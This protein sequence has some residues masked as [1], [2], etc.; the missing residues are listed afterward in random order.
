MKKFTLLFTIAV[1][2][3]TMAVAQSFT[4][5][6]TFDSIKAPV[7]TPPVG[8][9]GL[10]DPSPLPT[11]VTGVTFGAF[12]AVLTTATNPNAASRFSFV[13]WPAGGTNG[14]DVYSAGTI[15]TAEYYQVTLTP[16]SG[17]SISLTGITFKTQRSGTG[18]RNYAVRSSADSYAANLSASISPANANLSVQT[19]NVFF[20]ALDATTSGQVGSTITLS[21]A[22]FTNITSPITFRFY[23]WNSEATTGTFSI[24]DVAFMGSVGGTT[25]SVNDFVNAPVAV[26]YPNP[27]TDGIFTVN[28][29]SSVKTTVT[30]Y[31]IIGKVIFTKEINSA[32]ELIDLSYEANGSYFVNIKN[33]KENVTK[34]VTINK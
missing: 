1:I 5:T 34:K 11:A 6:Y 31:N 24:D 9:S 2:S 19:G 13:D 26:V 27:S 25:T 23:G 21:G 15:N 30:V 32:K 14:V 16:V 22:G 4:A 3:A 8:G 33:D 20:W 7:G 28:T 17:S 18:I 29:N 10:T 12:S